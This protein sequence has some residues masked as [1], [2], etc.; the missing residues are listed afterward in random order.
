MGGLQ[1][2]AAYGPFSDASQAVVNGPY[3][4]HDTPSGTGEYTAWTSATCQGALGVGYYHASPLEGSDRR[5]T[6]DPLTKEERADLEHFAAL[7]AAR[8]GCST[9]TG[10]AS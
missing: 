1:L 5:F 4:G 6:T 10:S 9:P 2:A 3:G 8:H 7:S